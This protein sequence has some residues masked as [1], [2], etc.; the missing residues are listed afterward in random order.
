MQTDEIN[1]STPAKCTLVTVHLVS[2]W[3]LI[4]LKLTRQAPANK[5]ESRRQ[6]EKKASHKALLDGRWSS[7]V[8]HLRAAIF[9]CEMRYELAEG[10]GFWTNTVATP[11]TAL[12][13]R[14]AFN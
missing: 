8:G 2:V 14:L 12:S 3:H 6:R 4:K 13:A 7:D 9:P 11:R 5:F 1:S 10:R